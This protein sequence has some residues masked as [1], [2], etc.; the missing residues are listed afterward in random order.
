MARH[1]GVGT[2]LASL[3]ID[4]WRGH[5][6][7][8]FLAIMRAGFWR[9]YVAALVFY[10]IVAAAMAHAGHTGWRL[11]A[12]IALGLAH[13]VAFLTVRSWTNDPLKVEQAVV[14]ANA[15]ILIVMAAMTALSGGLASPLVV[16]LPIL[17]LP[18]AL[19]IG[20]GRTTRI[21]ALSVTAFLISLAA[22]PIEVTGPPLPVPHREVLTVVASVWAMMSVFI[23]TGRVTAA[24]RAASDALGHLREE[25]LALALG[26]LR[27]LQSV[28]AKVAHE[29]KN[30]LA[31]VKGLVQLVA[32]APDG[33]RSRERLDVVQGEISR[34]ETILHEYLSFARPLEDL[35][36][37]SV[38]VA[39]VAEDVAAVLSARA[40]QGRV[41]LAVS[42]PPVR[43]KADPRRLKEAL[44][45][46]VANA[47]EFT[48]VDGR[49]DVEVAGHEGGARIQVRDTGRGISPDDLARV[50]TSFFTTR[51]S[52]TGL[53]VVLAKN[54]VAQHGG[55][56]QLTSEPG[57]GTT[58]TIQLPSAP[59]G[60]AVASPAPPLEAPHGTSPAGR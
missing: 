57:R 46:V 28:G 11:T 8:Q 25:R 12:V 13:S 50:G 4:V 35:A 21:L 34:M 41:A 56:F 58:V 59:P 38:D 31:A 30:P 27:R 53:G 29:L 22:V 24:T 60:A 26:Q 52:G 45:N 33:E 39:E 54:V 5:R 14:I 36:P 42:G 7:Q 43:L 10:A 40:E 19:V 32:R 49:V 9:S 23:F 2:S 6:N 17:V 51:A 18:S 47:I 44:L 20:L 3:E 15:K 1:A 48:P 37:Q 16:V 55:T